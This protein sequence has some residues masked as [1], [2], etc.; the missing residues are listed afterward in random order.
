MDFGYT[1]RGDG[2]GTF[3]RM[4]Y[5]LCGRFRGIQ[6][7]RAALAR[8]Y[9][10]EHVPGGRCGIPSPLRSRPE[11]GW[12]GPSAE[13]IGGMRLAHRGGI[14]FRLCGEQTLEAGCMGLLSG[15][16]KSDGSGLPP[17]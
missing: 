3:E 1:K 5:S 7:D 13:G 4:D 15:E 6:L 16:G 17:L 10:L 14:D 11:N 8:V 9:P 2:I 12:P